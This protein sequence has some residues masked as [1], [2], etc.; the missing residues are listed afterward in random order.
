[1]QTPLVM[2][3]VPNAMA[4]FSQLSGQMAARTGELGA[5]RVPRGLPFLQPPVYDNLTPL[6]TK[7]KDYKEGEDKQ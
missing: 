6:S 2:P 4:G 3:G 5:E 1:M 7:A